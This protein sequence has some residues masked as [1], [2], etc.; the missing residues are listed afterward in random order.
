[1]KYSLGKLILLVSQEV[2]ARACVGFE[3]PQWLNSLTETN[4]EVFVGWFF[5]LFVLLSSFLIFVFTCTLY[6]D[7]V[8][9]R[10]KP[11]TSG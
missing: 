10:G 8:T 5:C 3:I 4:S 6:F 11:T 2:W 9:E 1:M 7:S